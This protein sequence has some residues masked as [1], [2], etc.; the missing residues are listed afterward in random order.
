MEFLIWCVVLYFLGRRWLK[1][2]PE[3]AAAFKEAYRASHN[4]GRP[5]L[6]KIL[7]TK[8]EKTATPTKPAAMPSVKHATTTV[9]HQEPVLKSRKKS[10]K[11]FQEL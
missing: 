1:K 6:V 10:E 4:G 2:N 3:R 9:S 8:P 5:D 7:A 11:Q